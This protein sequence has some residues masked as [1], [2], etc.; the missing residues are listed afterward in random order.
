MREHEIHVFSSSSRGSGCSQTTGNEDIPVVGD[1]PCRSE[2]VRRR[3]HTM[4]FL[5]TAILLLLSTVCVASTDDS[6]DSPSVGPTE[7]CT[8][9]D[10]D[11]NFDG[12]GGSGMEPQTETLG[13]GSEK[14]RPAQEII[15]IMGCVMAMLCTGTHNGF[16]W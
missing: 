13:N 1:A 11:D 16:R 8:S 3:G 15:L 5:W 14:V 4:T 7:I 12:S 10:P 6:E 2:S 9:G